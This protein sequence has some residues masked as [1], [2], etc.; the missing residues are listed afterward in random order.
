MKG[1]DVAKWEKNLDI[2]INDFTAAEMKKPFGKIL[3]FGALHA[4]AA[5]D[6]AND[7]KINAK[8]E[9]VEALLKNFDANWKRELETINSN[10]LKEFSN[11]KCGARL[12]QKVKKRLEVF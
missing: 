9:D 4:A 1:A 7:D 12:F 10:L 6:D 2:K 11:F 8:E 5:S 3:E